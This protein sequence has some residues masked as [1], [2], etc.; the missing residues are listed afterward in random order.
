MNPPQEYFHISLRF[1]RGAY[2]MTKKRKTWFINRIIKNPRIYRGF[3]DRYYFLNDSS[4]FSQSG[5]LPSAFSA[6]SCSPFFFELPRPRPSSS[7]CSEAVMIYALL[8]SAHSSSTTWYI[9]VIP[10]TSWVS[11]WRADF[12]STKSDFS[13]IWESVENTWRT[14]N[15]LVRSNPWSR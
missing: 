10:H 2:G 1:I 8:W 4:D 3:L 11:S 7:P 15:S 6:A 9:G 14:I 12:G 5:R 13:R